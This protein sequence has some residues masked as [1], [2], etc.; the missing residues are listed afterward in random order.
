MAHAA[1]PAT[2]ERL[3]EKLGEV[4]QTQPRATPPVMPTGA[5][6]I[7]AAPPLAPPL[8]PPIAAPRPPVVSAPPASRPPAMPLANAALA[9]PG[10]GWEAYMFT[11]VFVVVGA[12]V[13]AL[14]AIFLVQ[15]GIQR[16]VFS[17]GRRDITALVAGVA[18]LAVGQWRRKHEGFWSQG[19]TAAGV[20]TLFATFFAATTLHHFLQPVHGF[21][22]LAATTATAV[23]LSLQDW[24]AGRGKGGIL[25]A[26]LGLLGGFITPILVNTGEDNVPGLFGYLILL[27]IGLVACTRLRGWSI[28][29]AGSVLFSSMWL[30]LWVLFKWNPAD[31]PILG[32]FMLATV[33]SLV[34]ATVTQPEKWHGGPRGTAAMALTW[35]AIGLGTLTS[36]LLLMRSDFDTLQWAFFA[37]L[38]AGA[39]VLARLRPAYE[40]IAWLASFLA[41]GLLLAWRAT[42]LSEPAA[43]EFVGWLA[44]FGVASVL[45]AYACQWKSAVP[46]RWALLAVLLTLAYVAA[47]YG[48]IPDTRHTRPDEW[49][50]LPLAVAVVLAALATPVFRQRDKMTTGERTLA[51]YAHGVLALLAIAPPMA[52][53]DSQ[54]TAAWCVLLP[55]TALAVWRLHIPGLL[56][57]F[58]GVLGLVVIC[59]LMVTTVVNAGGEGRTLF[60]N[61]VVWTYGSILLAMALA[62]WLLE[63]APE[64]PDRLRLVVPSPRMLRDILLVGSTAA[65]FVLL[66][67][68]VRWGFHDGKLN[69][70][71]AL[72]VE[73]T[74]FAVGWLL[75][76]MALVWMGRHLERA[77]LT[78]CGE[79]VGIVGLLHA[80][81]V[82]VV[83]TN[84]LW[85]GD[86]VGT[87]RV[88]NVLIYAYG[89]PAAMCGVLAYVLSWADRRALARAAG[90]VG[91]ILLFMMVTLQVRQGY[92]GEFLGIPDN[93]VTT[94]SFTEF[95]TYSILW[96]ALGAVCL[97]V[98]M[99]THQHLLRQAGKVLAAG[100]LLYA[101]AVVGI[102]MSPA[103]H[104]QWVGSWLVVNH[105]LYAYGTPIALAAFVSVLLHP[106]GARR[107]GFAVAEERETPAASGLQSML[108]AG[109]AALLFILLTTEI[110]QAFQ[111]AYLNALHMHFIERGTYTLAWLVLAAALLA[112]GYRTGLQVARSAGLI[113]AGIAIGWVLLICSLIW[114]PLWTAQA[115]GQTPIFNWLLYHYGVP[116]AGLVVLAIAL[117]N[118][119]ATERVIGWIAGISS[120]LLIFLTVTLEVQQF[121]RGDHL[122]W[123]RGSTT[124]FTAYSLAWAAM[125]AIYLVVGILRRS[126]LLRIASLAMMLLT[127]VKVFIFDLHDLQE[128]QRVFS[129]AG[130]GLSLMALAFVYQRFVFRLA[131]ASS[132]PP[133][134][135]EPLPSDKHT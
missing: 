63:H 8:A 73:R 43:P 78:L 26:S 17:A 115:V 12:I 51:V 29:A 70:L 9:R 35:L 1:P 19:L 125:G 15:I 102:I 95:A 93:D 41:L 22:L 77:V 96:M 118:R 79:V 117:W 84:P 52:L 97:L 132:E 69:D 94:V 6:Q 71:T 99:A 60:W 54:L 53:S 89:V 106:R 66:T 135:P 18:L 112:A 59:G 4:R 11:V 32:A 67:L 46:L 21:I 104:H 111:H 101:I 90:I 16:G 107:L 49:A 108:N 116:A 83:F 23:G 57:G 38:V 13:V 27:H 133:A 64:L 109:I 134:T 126:M 44:G 68:E 130:L 119:G 65:A 80:C 31:G 14:A 127:I 39:F 105:L 3:R 88:F 85:W 122:A 72:L 62:A 37:C 48:F 131:G 33:V 45:A 25:I 129:L 121:F 81:L 5:T 128:F 7:P 82:L 74:T 98:G 42:A 124:E 58:L 123:G 10:K 55:L 75:L 61:P 92:A 20:V 28:L 50:Y 120:L 30:G 76:A 24:S 113:V 100:G 40:A 34:V 2:S 110:R 103:L 36:C 47:A 114:N 91:L 86:N 56:M 87:W